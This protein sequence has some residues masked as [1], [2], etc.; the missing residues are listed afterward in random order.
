[1]DGVGRPVAVLPLVITGA[2]STRRSA[3]ATIVS[4]TDVSWSLRLRR[5]LVD[6]AEPIARNR[7]PS[8]V[9]SA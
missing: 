8:T 9:A 7:V 5:R 6:A 1:M 3:R 2:D 4:T